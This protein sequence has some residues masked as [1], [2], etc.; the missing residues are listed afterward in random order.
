MNVQI[1]AFGSEGQKKLINGVKLLAKAV[2]STLGPGGK[3]CVY[4]RGS[5]VQV[6]KDG[7]T[8]AKQVKSNDPLE[9]MGIDIIRQATERTAHGAGDGTT[10]SSLLAEALVVEGQKMVAAGY[11][12]TSIQRGILSAT[13]TIIDHIKQNYVHE[14][15]PKMIEHI[16]LVSTNWDEEI[17]SIIAEA[18]NKL[19]LDGAITVDASGR[20]ESSVTYIDGMQ[21][22]RGYLSPYFITN[23]AKQECVLD[24]PFICLLSEKLT[25]NSQL[26]PIL[27]KAFKLGNG[28]RPLLIVAPDVE[29]EALR[30]LVINKLRG[31]LNVCAIKCPGYGDRM[32]DYMYDLEALCGGTY[33]TQ[34][35]D[36]SI[37][38]IDA[39]D[40][41]GAD[42]V[43]ITRDD[44]TFISGH[45]T[46]EAIKN[47][48]NGIKDLL[49]NDKDSW[50]AREYK[51]R[52]ARLS[53]GV[54]IINVGAATEVELHERQDRVDDAVCATRAALEEGVVIGG[55]ATLAKI[56]KTNI[57]FESG[58]ASFNA[59]VSIVKEV[60]TAPL[61][62]LIINAGIKYGDMIIDKVSKKK[63]NI[64][65]DIKNLKFVDMLDAGIIDPA[66]V[67]CSALENAASVAG[68]ILT[69]ECL[70]SED[71]RIEDKGEEVKI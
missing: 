31:V 47:R 23:P 43:I 24:N 3:N 40:F 10:T 53:N 45:G 67:T 52:I 8:V 69:T 58:D 36:R 12:R 20:A 28:Q 66:K 55:G 19:G 18:V 30:T 37:D 46:E 63:N 42:R 29:Q 71:A 62:Q 61:R 33:F 64:G 21:V 13:K 34:L 15:T 70:I 65:F 38:N 59:G 4:N 35:T 68:L 39:S 32:K 25:N 51:E 54:A 16:A 11:N 6:T 49:E 22:P 57:K 27:E 9:Q 48:L 41:A 5:G 60:L 50:K 14:C 7:V 56:S 2:T 1:T 17:A 44:T 26:K